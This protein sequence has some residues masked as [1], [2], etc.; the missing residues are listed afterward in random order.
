[1]QGLSHSNELISRDEGLHCEF[2]CLLYSMLS[3]KLSQDTI[4]KIVS[5]LFYYYH[6]CSII[7]ISY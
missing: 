5:S 7:I 6:L 2:A 4:K 1:M 3:N